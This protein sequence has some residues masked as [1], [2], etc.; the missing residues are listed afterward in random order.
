[1]KSS[2]SGLLGRENLLHKAKN[3]KIDLN[4]GLEQKMPVFSFYPFSPDDHVSTCPVVT[5]D[6]FAAKK[7]GKYAVHL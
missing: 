3:P 2:H 7:I 6:F 4:D 5:A 1:V